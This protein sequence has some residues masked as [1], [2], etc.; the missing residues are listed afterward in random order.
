MPEGRFALA[1]ALGGDDGRDLFICT[2]RSLDVQEI[3]AT[4]GGGIESL[5]VEVPHAGRP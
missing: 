2:A 1:C 4:R 5:R 3:A